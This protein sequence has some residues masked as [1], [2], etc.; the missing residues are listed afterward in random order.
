M[1]ARRRSIAPPGEPEIIVLPDAEAVSRSAAERIATT[2][3]QGV[4]ARGRAD[5]ATTG[6]STPAGIYRHLAREPLRD[7][8]P[9]ELVHIWLG[10]ERFVPRG[11]DWCNA[12]IGD[13][14]LIAAGKGTALERVHL[15]SWPLDEALESG[16]DAA[17]CAEQYADQLRRQGLE[18]A[19]GMPAFDI[20]L[21]GIGPDGHVL[22]VFPGSSAFDSDSWTLAIPAPTHI[23]P[24]VERITM[25]PRVLDVAR[26]V[27][28][29][30]HGAGKAKILADI[31]GADRDPRRLPAQL[32]RRPGATWIL[33]EAGAAQIHVSP[34]TPRR[35]AAASPARSAAR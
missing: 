9:W 20:V 17:W 5:W 33:D 18:Q 14:D 34:A 35:V 32:A 11:D 27:I 12:R 28:A 3:R 19:D 22:S 30:A 15:H 2:L 21:L 6:G 8:V 23:G 26:Q 24:M 16:R 29:V 31:F 4:A 1:T 13:R 10:D 7:S 25:N